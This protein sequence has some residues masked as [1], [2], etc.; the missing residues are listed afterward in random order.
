M[1]AADA[2]RYAFLEIKKNRN[3]ETVKVDL[4]GKTVELKYMRV[5]ILH[6]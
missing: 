6:K 3:G 1:A 5:Y 4:Q 2:S